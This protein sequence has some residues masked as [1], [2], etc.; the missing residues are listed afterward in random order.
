[1]DHAERRALEESGSFAP[2]ALDGRRTLRRRI[3]YYGNA[4]RHDEL[5]VEVEAAAL[6]QAG[7]LLLHLRIRRRGDGR[8]IAV[9]SVEKLL[10]G[11]A[12]AA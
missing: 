4:E 12:A 9:S 11:G 2:A 10:A 7:R 3:G 8:L 5:R 1:M 6:P